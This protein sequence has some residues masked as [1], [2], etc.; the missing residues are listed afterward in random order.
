MPN[1]YAT[2][3]PSKGTYAARRRAS[4]ALE[5]PGTKNEPSETLE[6][7]FERLDK[8]LRALQRELAERVS[9]LE[10][11]QRQRTEEV[12]GTAVR[13]LSSQPVRVA[14]DGYQWN[15]IHEEEK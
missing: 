9:R 5:E 6:Q 2:F 14:W 8:E 3:D 12:D 11:T 1:Q 13:N 10:F 7:R 4:K 15:V